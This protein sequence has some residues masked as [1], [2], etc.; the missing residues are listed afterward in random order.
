MFNKHTHPHLCAGAPGS[1]VSPFALVGMG[2]SVDPIALLRSQLQ[3]RCQAQASIRSALVSPTGTRA[4]ASL[5]RLKSRGTTA[6]TKP[7]PRS[8]PNAAARH[9][10]NKRRFEQLEKKFR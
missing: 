9:A 3:G 1:K 2:A 4:P 5:P 7:S 6:A 10:E 8:L